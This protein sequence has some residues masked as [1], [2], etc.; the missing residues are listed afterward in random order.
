MDVNITQTCDNSVASS[1]VCIYSGRLDNVQVS[2][3]M[4]EAMGLISLWI[5]VVFFVA[6]LINKLT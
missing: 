1:S 2:I 5:V 6:F 3:P 4:L